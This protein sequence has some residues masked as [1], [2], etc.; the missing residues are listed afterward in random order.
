MMANH[1]H[2]IKTQ[3]MKAHTH[4]TFINNRTPPASISSLIVNLKTH[5][6]VQG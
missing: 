3:V 1:A 2:F 6:V 4:D 5:S